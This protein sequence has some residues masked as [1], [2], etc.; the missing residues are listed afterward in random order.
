MN[1]IFA[2]KMHMSSG[3]TEK[4]DRVGITL[5]SVPV[6][7]VKDLKN[8]EK[9]GYQAVRMEVKVTPKKSKIREIRTDE[10]LE[11][12][13][14]IKLDE[15][16]KAGDIVQMTAISKGKGFTSVVKRHHFKGGPR[17]HGTSDRERAPGSSGSGTTP[18]RVFKGKRRAGHM[19]VETTTHR[20]VEI[21]SVDA[22]KRIIAVIG[23]VPGNRLSG[24]VTLIKK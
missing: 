21:F 11:T 24:L 6:M 15:V 10:A 4:G 13:T 1:T 2:N 3:F 22:E 7:T 17:T 8:K 16:L 20:G 14:E 9:H 18:G 19:G 5:L 23:N 12:G